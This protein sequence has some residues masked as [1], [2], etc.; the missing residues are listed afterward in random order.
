MRI[1]LNQRSALAITVILIAMGVAIFFQVVS[2][3]EEPKAVW[4]VVNVSVG[5]S[6]G[7]AHLIDVRGSMTL[8]DAGLHTQAK[9]YLVPYLQKLKITDIDRIFV[10]HAHRD[11]YEGIRTILRAGIAVGKIFLKVPPQQI[12][13]RERFPGGCD[14]ED[15]L[16]FIQ[17]LESAGVQVVTPSTGDRIYIG[18]DSDMLVL[19]AQEDDLPG[20]PIDINDLS[21][22]MRWSISGSRVLFT[23]DLNHKIGSLLSEDARMKSQFLKMPHHGAMGHAPQKF[24]DQVD[25]D[26]AV[27]PGPQFI[28]CSERGAVARNWVESNEVLTWVSGIDGNLRIE[29]FENEATVTPRFNVPDCRTRAFGKVTIP[30]RTF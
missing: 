27:V 17:E 13:E 4:H 26:V 20:D 22:I 11:H 18:S 24:F 14:Y 3:T 16:D 29:F 8:I 2:R 12:C 1:V 5:K 6:V 21:L 25:P 10:S 19:H 23:G 30:L 7:N 28:W 15:F 9:R